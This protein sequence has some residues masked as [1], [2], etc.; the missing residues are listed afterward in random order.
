VAAAEHDPARARGVDPGHLTTMRRAAAAMLLVGGATCAVG[1]VIT[2]RTEFGKIGHGSFGAGFALCGLLVLTTRPRRWVMQGFV[3]LSIL[4]LSGLMATSDPIGTG[5]F[6]FLWP[7]V[8]AAYFCSPRMLATTVGLMAGTLPIGLALNASSHLKMDTFTGTLSSV[9]L[10]AVLIGTM[11]RRETRLRAELALAA[12]TDPLT[13]LLNRRA[14]NPEFAA[15]VAE[16]VELDAPISVVMLDV[17]HFKRFNDDHGHIAGDEALRRVAVLLNR[18]SGEHD[19]VARFGG[20]EF[21]VA[22]PGA[23]ADGARRYAERLGCVLAQEADVALRVTLSAGIATL[24]EELDTVDALFSRADDALYAAKDA[25]RA[26]AAWWDGTI[27]VGEV[28]GAGG[29]LADELRGA[30]AGR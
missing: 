14:F 30:L 24:S 22:L 17:D 28:I 20:E 4:F 15:L 29:T 21:A 10:M 11:T 23:D 3:L 2:Q 26:R 16:A 1:V 27:Q 7:V 12:D 6:F 18:H 13:G 25:G 8:Y 19:L 5:P 9:G